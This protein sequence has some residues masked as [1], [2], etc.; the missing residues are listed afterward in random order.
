MP[1]AIRSGEEEVEG[2][3][4]K[5]ADS[6]VKNLVALSV[7]QVEKMMRCVSNPVLSLGKCEIVMCE[8]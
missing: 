1:T 4:E 5:D 7:G 3:E 8:A 6:Y 2:E